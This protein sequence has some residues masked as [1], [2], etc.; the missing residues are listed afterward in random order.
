MS[1]YL[2]CKQIKIIFQGKMTA[3]SFNFY[4]LLLRFLLMV[5]KTVSDEE[6]Y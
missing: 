6:S 3:L 1:E 5:Q 2:H 4:K